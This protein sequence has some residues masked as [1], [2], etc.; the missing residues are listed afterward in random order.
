MNE[1]QPGGKIE[2]TFEV[3][4]IVFFSDA[5][6]AIAMTLLAIELKVPNLGTD[7]TTERL[8]SAI[9]ADWSHLF[10]FALSFWIVAVYWMAHHRYFRYIK[11]YD[12]GLI[13]RNLLAL[14]FI[15]FMPF[16]TLVLGEYGNLAGAVWIYAVNMTGLGLAGAWLWHHATRGHRLV[17]P[18]LNDR[19][20]RYIQARAFATPAVAVIVILASFFIG[21]SASTGWFL[22]WVFQVLLRRYYGVPE[23]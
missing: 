7:Q 9:F 19:F 5:V 6:F 16:S 10:A 2:R 1:K 21:G 4:R 12:G 22:I 17:D 3:E 18:D 20:I 8:L 14:F 11:G 13:G 23:P 15:A